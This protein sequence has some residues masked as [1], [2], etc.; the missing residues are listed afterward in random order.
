MPSTIIL[1]IIIECKAVC[2]VHVGW[3]KVLLV[4]NG[5]SG[6]VGQGGKDVLPSLA[7]LTLSI[8]VSS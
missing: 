6:L 2:F 4:E 7:V 1:Y 5:Q 3:C 8:F